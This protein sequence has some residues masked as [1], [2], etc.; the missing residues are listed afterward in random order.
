[1]ADA[2]P[3][4]GPLLRQLAAD[5]RAGAFESCAARAGLA[6][7]ILWRL[8]I[9]KLRASNPQFLAANGVGE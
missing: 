6:R 7:A 1:M 2:G 5:L 4:V 3:R 8:T 9:S